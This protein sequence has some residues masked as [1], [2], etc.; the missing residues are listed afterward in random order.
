MAAT[1]TPNLRVGGRAQSSTA[2]YVGSNPRSDSLFSRPRAQNQTLGWMSNHSI[3]Y[4]WSVARWAGDLDKSIMNGQIVFIKQDDETPKVKH[5]AYTMLNLP[6]CNYALYRDHLRNQRDAALGGD[7]VDDADEITRILNTYNVVGSVIND[8]NGESD[9]GNN[10]DR[11]VNVCISGRQTT[12]NIWGELHDGDY[13]YL[14][15]E[16]RETKGTDFTL[17]HR[18]HEQTQPELDTVLCYQWVPY[19][20]PD[21]LRWRNDSPNPNTVSPCSYIELGRVFRCQRGKEY[22]M[23]VPE[24]MRLVNRVHD[25]VSKTHMFEIHWNIQA[26]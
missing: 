20:A 23:S 2:P 24:R 9:Y 7:E 6:M 19:R 14:K 8:V 17:Q 15:L 22:D 12:F 5:K 10:R 26:V 11:V 3:P 21:S 16:K 4:H 18:T 25:M 13:I 1:S